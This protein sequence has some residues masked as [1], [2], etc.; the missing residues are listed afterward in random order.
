MLS[1]GIQKYSEG[2]SRSTNNV[3]NPSCCSSLQTQW[4]GSCAYPSL[5]LDY[6][7]ASV[8][9]WLSDPIRFVW[10]RCV[11]PGYLGCAGLKVFLS[12]P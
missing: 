4:L 8:C 2:G 6:L 11:K 9:G 7:S 1:G 12:F 3:L 10:C 5:G